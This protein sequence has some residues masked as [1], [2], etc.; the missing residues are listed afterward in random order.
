MFFLKY[1]PNSK[2]ETNENM[3]VNPWDRTIRWKNA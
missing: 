3:S 2:S 1:F